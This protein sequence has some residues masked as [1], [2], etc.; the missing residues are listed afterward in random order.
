M[1]V[2][3]Q[4]NI[5]SKP[6]HNGAAGGRNQKDRRYLDTFFDNHRHP[7]RFPRGRPWCGP[8]E[9]SANHELM[10][11]DGFVMGDLMQGEYVENED[12][13]NDRLATIQSVWHA[14]WTPQAKYFRYNYKR[15]LITFDYP[16]L[17]L[18]EKREMETYYKAAAKLGAKLNIRVEYG[19]EPDFQ[20]TADLGSPMSYVNR[21][22]LAEAAMAGDPWL[23][24]FIDEPNQDLAAILGFNQAGLKIVSYEPE[25]VVTPTQV[26]AMPDEGLLKMIAEM[27]AQ[28]AAAAVDRALAARDEKGPKRTRKPSDPSELAGDAA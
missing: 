4:L 20:I 17:I 13:S 15:K 5:P 10:H 18:D 9:L 1:T 11:E 26:L 27:A 2:P 8:R 22:R 24:G 28:A 21:I 12:G 25:P 14:P 7:R 3:F 23:L 19:V 16:R 6:Q